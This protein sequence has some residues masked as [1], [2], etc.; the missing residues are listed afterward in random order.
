MTCR[1]LGSKSKPTRRKPSLKRTR[2]LKRHNIQFDTLAVRD[3]QG[4][5]I[6]AEEYLPYLWA[7]CKRGAFDSQAGFRDDLAPRDFSLIMRD[8]VEQFLNM[9]GEVVVPVARIDN[10]QIPVGVISIARQENRAYPH[11]IWF[12][13]ASARLRLEIGV[14][15]IVELKKQALVLITAVER[16]IH[17]FRHLSRYGLLKAVGKIQGYTASG[18]DVMLFQS[19]GS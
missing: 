14:K 1:K 13:E 3:Q 7:A 18:D 2:A 10:E 11:V 4:Q 12:P 9:G 17:Y 6:M 16:D 15:F 19:A 8:R 5:T